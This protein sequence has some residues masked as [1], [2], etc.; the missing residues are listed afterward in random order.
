MAKQLNSLTFPEIGEYTL[1]H[2]ANI[3]EPSTSGAIASFADGANLPVADLLVG[4]EAVQDLHGY[5]APW[6]GGAGKNKLDITFETATHNQVTYTNNGDGTVKVNGTA[7]GVS[8]R[9]LGD[10][11]LVGGTSYALSGGQ[12]ANFYLVVK[13]HGTWID[14]GSGATFTPDSDMTAT[15]QV[16][17]LSGT[18]V[19]NQ[20]IYPMVRLASTTSE[21]EPYANI[22]PISGWTGANVVVSPTLDAQD[23]TTYSVTWQSEAGTVYGGTLDVTTGELV[24]DKGYLSID[25]TTNWD[26]AVTTNFRYFD[27][28][29]DSLNAT[30]W[31]T[32]VE[33]NMFYKQPTYPYVQLNGNKK[34]R[35]C[36]ASSDSSVTTV[37]QLQ[38]LLTQNNLQ[39]VYPL[40]TPQTYQLTQ[41]E[42]LTLLGENN[43][44]A[45]CGD[46]EN[47]TYRADT[48][49]YIDGTIVDV[50]LAMIASIETGTT[51]SKAYAVGDY[52][53]LNGNQ[54]CKAQTA[55]ASGA[56]FTL[57]TNYTVT[58]IGAELKL[59]Q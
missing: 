8:Y 48:K 31:E 36:Y 44:F 3:I 38:A 39:I 7:S 5:N 14:T 6:V 52:F 19:N 27:A 1:D 43:I 16:V 21:W 25:G 45:D 49:K 12:N 56:T 13:G 15:I 51:A 47:V 28:Q 35:V 41:T 32:N 40:A 26:L 23:G 17:V 46:V 18:N 50:P 9:D 2:K 29:M 10:V 33:T 58:T 37:A 42:V 34:V 30:A 11:N 55:I 57:N 22:C 4:I 53:I 59:L 20:T 54:F 24:V